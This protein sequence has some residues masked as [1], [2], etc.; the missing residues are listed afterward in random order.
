[1]RNLI[2]G[3]PSSPRGPVEGQPDRV[4]AESFLGAG[5]E[6]VVVGDFSASVILGYRVEKGE[7]VGQVKEGWWRATCTRCS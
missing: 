1:M 7:V 4:I 5:Q 6:N 3:A 2:E